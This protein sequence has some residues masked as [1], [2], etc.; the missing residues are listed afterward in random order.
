[1]KAVVP[2]EMLETIENCSF[3][4]S[5]CVSL[6]V[7]LGWPTAS[8]SFVREKNSP[9]LMNNR[10]SVLESDNTSYVSV[11]RKINEILWKETETGC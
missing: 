6:L 4:C 2:P 7:I 10:R 3:Q 5:S 9:N 11:C 1:M 8:P